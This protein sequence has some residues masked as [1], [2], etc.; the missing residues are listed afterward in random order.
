[1][2]TVFFARQI[3]CARSVS[4]ARSHLLWDA[5]RKSVFL[6]CVLIMFAHVLL[7]MDRFAR[8]VLP[9]VV[10]A[11]IFFVLANAPP[12]MTLLVT[13]VLTAFLVITVITTMLSAGTV[14]HRVTRIATNR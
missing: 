10:I 8:S 7:V 4:T 9:C 5:V 6:V 1:M 11:A 3:M 13:V 12:V 14:G 2:T